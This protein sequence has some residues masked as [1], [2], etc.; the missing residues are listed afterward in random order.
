MSNWWVVKTETEELIISGDD[1]FKAVHQI[2]QDQQWLEVPEGVAV[3]NAKV[4]NTSDVLS[5]VDGAADKEGPLWDSFRAA[6]SAKLSSCDWTQ[7]T[8][9]PLASEV[10][11]AWATYRQA[12]RDLP[13]STVDPVSPSWPEHP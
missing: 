9:S 11:T 3:G 12:L 10:K 7:L 5:L 13:A 4:L 6:R 2:G 1:A 8:D